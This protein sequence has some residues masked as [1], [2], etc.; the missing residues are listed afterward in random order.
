MASPK[1]KSINQTVGV[2]VLILVRVWSI[3]V[4]K[5]KTNEKIAKGEKATVNAKCT[6]CGEVILID[7]SKD[8][9]IC[10]KCGNA[11]VSEKA[12]SLF[13]EQNGV[14]NSNRKKVRHVWKSLGRGILM[15]LE[16]IGYLFFVLFFIWLFVDITDDL[17]KK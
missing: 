17:K 12:I 7:E 10:P 14:K 9:N 5:Y 15:F 16:C 6:D 11:F 4:W 8:A 2:F 1:N 13:K 3:I